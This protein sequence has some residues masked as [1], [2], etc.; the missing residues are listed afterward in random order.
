M[1]ET[2]QEITIEH[3]IVRLSVHRTCGKRK[4]EKHLQR[5]PYLRAQ[6]FGCALVPGMKLALT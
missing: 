3:I 2:F 5:R 6:L 4:Q 1:G